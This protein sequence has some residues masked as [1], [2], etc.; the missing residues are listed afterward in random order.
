MMPFSDPDGV[1]IGNVDR[2]C[3]DFAGDASGEKKDYEKQPNV[4]GGQQS[5][6]AAGVEAEDAD[7]AAGFEFVQQTQGDQEAAQHEEQSDG[8][9]A[10]V[11]R[12]NDVAQDDSQSCEGTQAGERGNL[13]QG[14]VAEQGIAAVV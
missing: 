14:D 10:R 1:V 9:A 11:E 2:C 6:G 3:R 13:F 12:G 7:G 8:L 5:A 4:I